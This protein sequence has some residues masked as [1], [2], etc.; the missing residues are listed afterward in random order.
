MDVQLLPW[1]VFDG[2]DRKGPPMGVINHSP[3]GSV[4]AKDDDSHH[5]RLY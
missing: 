5:H 2:G 1:E 4:D 3:I